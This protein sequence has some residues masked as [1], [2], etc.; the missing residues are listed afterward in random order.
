MII[1][2]ELE[3]GFPTPLWTIRADIVFSI[4]NESPRSRFAL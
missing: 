2:D 1:V 4:H 3:D